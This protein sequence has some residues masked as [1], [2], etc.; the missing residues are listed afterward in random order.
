[1]SPLFRLGSI[2]FLREGSLSLF[3]SSLLRSRIASLIGLRCLPRSL[4]FDIQFHH[5]SSVSPN[6]LS[7]LLRLILIFSGFVSNPLFYSPSYFLD[8]I[9]FFHLQ[10]PSD[11]SRVLQFWI[12]GDSFCFGF[13]VLLNK[14]IQKKLLQRVD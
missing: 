2:F 4:P 5:H 3:L 10:S 12:L 9:L 8:F 11:L 14:K 13:R 1:M 7:L 6:N